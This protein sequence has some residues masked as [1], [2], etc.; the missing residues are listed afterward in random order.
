MIY[1][2]NPQKINEREDALGLKT[3]SYAPQILS[4]KQAG[5]LYVYGT[6]NPLKYHDP[7]GS[8]GELT[9]TWTSSMWWLLLADGPLPIGD[10]IYGIGV[11]AATAIDAVNYVGID[12]IVRMASDLPDTVRNTFRGGGLNTPPDPNWGEG[13]K[14]FLCLSRCPT[15][16][17]AGKSFGTI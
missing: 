1:G 10:V 9:L 11:V 2:D 16:G 13:F 5:N 17:D 8:A 14:T 4:I 12:N 3:Y 15:A 7:S 6:S